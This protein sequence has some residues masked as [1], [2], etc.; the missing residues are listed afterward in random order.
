MGY[1]WDSVHQA[2][3]IKQDH[4]VVDLHNNASDFDVE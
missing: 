3:C 2:F 4:G 1:V